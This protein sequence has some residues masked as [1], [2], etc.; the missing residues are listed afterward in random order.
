[1]LWESLGLHHY[2]FLIIQIIL[3]KMIEC[4]ES[5]CDS[6]GSLVCDV[7]SACDVDAPHPADAFYAGT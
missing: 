6:A 3:L 1:M 7:V 5:I 4:Q 2:C